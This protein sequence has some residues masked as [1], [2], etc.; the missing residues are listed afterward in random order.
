MQ[1]PPQNEGFSVGRLVLF[2]IAVGFVGLLVYRYYVKGEGGEYSNIPKEVQIKYVP[3]D[4]K[5]DLDL[6]NALPILSNPYRYSREFDELIHDFN[7]SLLNHVAN[8]MN[9]SDSLKARV[10]IEYEKHHPYVRK[11]MFNDFVALKDT[12]ATLYNTWYQ[13]EMTGAVDILNE[14][15]SKYTCFLVNQI[16]A[17]LLKTEEG[18]IYVK[19]EQVNTPCGVAI[20]EALNPMIARMKEKAAIEDFS[21][22]KGI[23][24]ERV[25]RAITELGTMEIRD[26]KGIGAKKNTKF[27]GVDVSSTEMEMSAISILKVGFKLDKFFD[28]N[29]SSKTKIVTVTL[30]EPEVLSHEVFPKIDKLDVGWL[31]EIEQ[32]DF[33]R[34]MDLLRREFRQEALESDVM[35]KSKQRAADIMDTML[36]PLIKGM[37]K[38][39]QLKVKFKNINTPLPEEEEEAPFNDLSRKKTDR[40]AALDSR[41]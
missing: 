29:L 25:E 36:T 41:N 11:L 9:L 5:T 23:L 39:Y 31:R 22:S 37:N 17:T 27:L 1:A 18:K 34:N 16:M 7:L 4:F 19:G 30:P 24:Q 21:R 14:V 26:R 20:S 38:G 35:E 28:I 33:N 3:S 10:G 40:A 6:E 15:A 32:D 8:R 12:S 2:F 13:N